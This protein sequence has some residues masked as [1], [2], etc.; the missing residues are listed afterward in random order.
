[1]YVDKTKHI[2]E[3]IV[4]AKGTYF[5][6]ARNRRTGKSLICSAIGEMFLGNKKLFKDLWIS[7][8]NVWDFEAEKRPVIHLDMSTVVGESKAVFVVL[9]KDELLS[10]AK[11]FGIADLDDNLPVQAILKKLI[12]KLKEK[13]GKPV[14]VII[15]EYDAPVTHLLGNLEELTKVQ[16]TLSEFYGVLKGIDADLRLVYITG[17]LKFSSM[18]LFSKLNN[19]RDLTFEVNA[20]TMVGYEEHE[21]RETFPRAGLQR[22]QSLAGNGRSPTQDHALGRYDRARG[23][24]FRWPHRSRERAAL[25]RG[26]AGTCVGGK[27]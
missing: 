7:K 22:R 16:N 5:F 24:D 17:I 9:L 15:D 11:K 27:T 19:L 13:S 21:I 23:E 1:L 25:Q 26:W 2:F 12:A 3:N 14:V 20:G 8:D 18:S 6:L 10:E 4:G